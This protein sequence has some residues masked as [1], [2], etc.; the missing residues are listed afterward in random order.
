MEK[1][2]NQFLRLRPEDDHTLPLFDYD[3]PISMDKTNFHKIYFSNAL[4]LFVDGGTIPLKTGDVFELESTLRFCPGN[5][6]KNFYLD[7]SWETTEKIKSLGEFADFENLVKTLLALEYTIKGPSMFETKKKWFAKKHII[8]Q[9]KAD[10]LIEN[11][12]LLLENKPAKT[13]LTDI[14]SP[15]ELDKILET[16]KHYAQERSLQDEMDMVPTMDL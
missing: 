7:K 11:V 2:L 16:S 1:F 12:N 13:N 3:S 5:P 9:A 4:S 10:K 8:D 15:A 14:I 6:K